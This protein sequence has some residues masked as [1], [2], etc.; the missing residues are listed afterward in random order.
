M[1][2]AEQR[3]GQRAQPFEP[4]EAVVDVVVERGEDARAAARGD[5]VALHGVAAEE[6]ARALL[7]VGAVAARVP[8]RAH[9][10]E[11]AAARL[12]DVAV[13][14]DPVDGQVAAAHRDLH[15]AD[16]GDV[17]RAREAI[18]EVVPLALDGLDPDHVLERR[19]DRE[20][21][22]RPQARMPAHVVGVAV[23][24][25]QPADL[26]RVDADA[27]ERVREDGVV[28]RRDAAVDQRRD[29]AADQV[30][31]E[32]G[33]GDRRVVRRDAEDPIGDLAGLSELHQGIRPI[34]PMKAT[35]AR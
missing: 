7:E 8:A 9:D 15:V 21:G 1:R 18:P 26:A 22:V 24:E 19:G 14:Q 31:P 34:I 3:E 29:G 12:E 27:R 35:M 30:R 17:E 16:A 13:A 11:A 32:R 23:R 4:L 25:Q 6:H 2:A 20:R 10:P 33:V 5:A 28:G